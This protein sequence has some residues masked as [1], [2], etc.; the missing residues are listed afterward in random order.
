MALLDPELEHKAY[1]APGK[2]VQRRRRWDGSC[3]TEDER[4]HEEA[5]WGLRIAFHVEVNAH[6]D[7]GADDK[8]K[9]EAG[10]DTAGGEHAVRADEAPDD[11]GGE[12]DAAAGAGEVVGLVGLAD[13]GDV[14][15]G[16]VEDDDLD[17]AGEG[18]G[19]YLGEEHGPGRDF[20]V[21]AEFEVAHE[22][23]CLGHGDVAK[24][25]EAEWSV[26]IA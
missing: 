18:C 19:D 20:H 21:M 14:G 4:R 12:E 16:E 6:G 26:R 1:Y 7:D 15:E 3:S 11:G 22:G 10:V 23:Q 8:E 5:R 2:V 25:L 17:E 24:R 13:V 9:E